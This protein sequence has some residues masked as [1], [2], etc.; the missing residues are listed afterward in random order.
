M[1]CT[2]CQKKTHSPLECKQ[3]TLELCISCYAPERHAC[4]NITV[5]LHKCKMQLEHTL[6]KSA[7][8]AD[9]IEERLN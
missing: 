3:C 4:K 2:H 6:I 1:K 5:F 7:C 9:K 8:V